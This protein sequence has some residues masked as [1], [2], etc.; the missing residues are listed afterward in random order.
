MFCQITLAQRSSLVLFIM[1]MCTLELNRVHWFN[2]VYSIHQNWL[3]CY[4]QKSNMSLHALIDLN[5]DTTIP[6][7]F[8]ASSLP[9]ELYKTSK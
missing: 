7:I 3:M 4:G 8:L 6:L 5:I 9:G 2:L 1:L